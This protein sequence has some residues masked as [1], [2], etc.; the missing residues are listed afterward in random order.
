MIRP[1][2]PAGDR[3]KAEVLPMPELRVLP[4][5]GAVDSPTTVL[6]SGAVAFSID[7]VASLP[8]INRKTVAAMIDRGELAAVRYARRRWV[9]AH[10]LRELLLMA[11]AEEGSSAA[12][13]S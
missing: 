12:S 1:R 8:R 10:A 7:E 9:P 4:D 2:S 5:H 13:S 3:D 11:P 6:E